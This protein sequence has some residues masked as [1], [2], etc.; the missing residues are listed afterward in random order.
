M[1]VFSKKKLGSSGEMLQHRAEG[2]PI[3]A[4]CIQSAHISIHQSGYIFFSKINAQHVNKHAFSDINY[5]ALR[6][7][8][9]SQ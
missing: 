7:V 5:E 9:H 4:L 1:L 3:A 2:L 6:K 8:K